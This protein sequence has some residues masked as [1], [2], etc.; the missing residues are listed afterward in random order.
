MYNPSNAFVSAADRAVLAQSERNY[1]SAIQ[2][3]ETQLAAAYPTAPAAATNVSWPDLEY[4]L[5]NTDGSPGGPFNNRYFERNDAQTFGLNPTYPIGGALLQGTLWPPSAGAGS[6]VPLWVDY[7]MNPDLAAILVFA[8][9]VI[10]FAVLMWKTYRATKNAPRIA[11]QKREAERAR[12][13]AAD[14]YRNTAFESYPDPQA[15]CRNYVA[16]MEAQGYDMGYYKKMCGL[17]AP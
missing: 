1:V 13:E 11:A 15:K 4:C 6:P 2:N 17:S 14:P 7:V 9:L 3:S 8:L 10:I 5:W 16:S 12:L